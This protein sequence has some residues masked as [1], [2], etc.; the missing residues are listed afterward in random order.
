MPNPIRRFLQIVL[1]ERAA[2]KAA[3]DAKR[4]LS[5]VGRALNGIKRIAVGL[6]TA[7][8][9][10]FSIRQ[11]VDWGK[12]AVQ[13]GIDAEETLSKF[14]TTFRESAS[15]LDGFISDWVQLAGVTQSAGRDMAATAG[16]IAQ[17]FG[18]STQESADFSARMIQLTGDL[19]SFHNVPIEETFNAL[20]SGLTETEPLKRFGIVLSVAEVKL[21]AL[22]ETGKASEDQLTRQEIVQA[23]LNLIY[24]RAG[25][26]IGDLDRTSGSLSNRLRSLSG[27]WAR[28][29]EAV[30]LAIIQNND[31]TSVIEVLQSAIED[32][33]VWV[34]NN[35]EAFSTIGLVLNGIIKTL[36]MVIDGW[37]RLFNFVSAGWTGFVGMI[38]DGSANIVDGL[39]L[40]LNGLAG[41]KRFFGLA[42]GAIEEAADT[43]E[44]KARSLRQTATD[45]FRTMEDLRDT[46]T[47]SGGGSPTGP[48]AD[49]TGGGAPTVTTPTVEAEDPS[50]IKARNELMQRGIALTEQLRTAQEIYNDTLEELHT[51]REAGAIDDET[52][53]RGMAE[54]KRVLDDAKDSTNEY[55]EALKEA[56][57]IMAEHNDAVGAFTTRSTGMQAEFE[58]L[59]QEANALTRALERMKSAG[60]DPTDEAYVGLESRLGD[61]AE[62]IENVQDQMELAGIVAENTGA[63]LGG[64]LGGN[65]AD[66]AAGKA[67]QNALLA[68]EQ[69]VEGLVAS[70]NPFTAASAGA[71]FA[72]S[73][74]Y[75]ALS[76]GWAALASS[77]GGPGGGTTSAGGGGGGGGGGVAR[78]LGGDEVNGM[79]ENEV[80]IH[81]I[82]PGFSAVNPE[83]QRVVAGALEEVNQRFGDNTSVRIH[84]N[85]AP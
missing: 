81:F 2:R 43:L 58:L 85:N 18:L 47:R 15:T 13:A 49:G 50:V 70:L 35:G 73:A 20:R 25:V 83:V 21:R 80:H 59:T 66:V 1:D 45:L 53:R 74:K 65:L 27:T 71:H 8:V 77:L 76:A 5:A 82:G 63:L 48:Q 62:A 57:D 33:T 28:L 56:R 55:A 10:A 24:E 31:A 17:G 64:V 75:A 46:A 40:V 79:K 39:A 38:V 42:E 37:W 9:A 68:A 19:T 36:G 78:G 30:G 22:A 60:I 72:A 61:T 54:A 44:A 7:I 26:A 3:N 12:A 52:F 14:N 16:S 51:L 69:A 4:E 32:L 29:Q 41:V 34:Q 6:G 23:R 84:R 67:K 11:I